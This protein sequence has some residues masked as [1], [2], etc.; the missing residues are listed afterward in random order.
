MRTLRITGVIGSAA[1]LLLAGTAVFAEER[2]ENVAPKVNVSGVNRGKP[3]V[4]LEE[5]KQNAQE[6][7]KAVRVEA[8]TRVTALKEKAA[9][10]VADIQDKAKQQ[11]A[12]RLTKQ[13][14]N[15]NDRWTDRFMQLLDR[16]D[17]VTKKIQD[18]AD[19][20]AGKG[21]DVTTATAAIQSAQAAIESARAAVTAQAAK[22]YVLDTSA[23]AVTTST[24]TPSGQVELMKNLRTSFQNLHKTLFKDLFAL[25]DG[26]MKDARKAV[27]SA[28]Q[29]LGKIPG[30]DEGTATSAAATSA[31]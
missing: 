9:E 23:V 21:R 14:G 29:T 2:P 12:E 10:R 6:R 27:Q 28:L 22:T 3:V 18:R 24:T 16:Y 25:R 20:A 17:A 5:V 7:M 13:F 1:I 31:Q 19:I 26:P 11:M 4:A 8:Q 30:V 15:I